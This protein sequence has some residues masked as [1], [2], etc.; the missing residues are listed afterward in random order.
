MYYIMKIVQN[1]NFFA[2]AKKKTDFGL[3]L[4]CVIIA[5]IRVLVGNTCIPPWLKHGIEV[6]LVYFGNFMNEMTW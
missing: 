2:T 1:W 4:I 3:N 6:F 5:Q